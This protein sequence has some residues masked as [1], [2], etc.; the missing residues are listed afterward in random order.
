MSR[1]VRITEAYCG[2]EGSNEGCNCDE[3]SCSKYSQINRLVCGCPVA[4]VL[5]GCNTQPAVE[6]EETWSIF[7][8]LDTSG[9][10]A[11]QL[12]FIS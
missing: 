9:W 3:V 5:C 11:C 10:E 12:S 1:L 4:Y 7:F 8:L 6:S 2:A